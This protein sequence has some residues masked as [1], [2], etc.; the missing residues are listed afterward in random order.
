MTPLPPL[1]EPFGWRDGQITVDAP[2]RAR[3][4]HDARSSGDRGAPIDL[5][6]W[7]SPAGRGEALAAAPG[8]PPARIAQSHQV[9]EARVRAIVSEA[10]LQAPPSDYDA[11]VTTLPRRRLR[12]AHRRLPADRPDRAGGRRRRPRGLAR[13]RARRRAGRRRRAA[14]ARRDAR[15]APRSGRAP[16]SA[17][18]RPGRRSTRRSPASAPAPGA[19][20]TPTSPPSRAAILEQRG[21]D[22]DPRHRAVHDLRSPDAVLVPPPRG[23][24]RGPAGGGA[25]RS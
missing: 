4:L 25:W 6:R 17:A 16:A 10:D 2:G 23:R 8:S 14:R 15:S 12:R 24:G 20:R 1:P 19:A 22:G 7:T 11:Q 5:K 21:R 9:H 13:A 18:T 3:A